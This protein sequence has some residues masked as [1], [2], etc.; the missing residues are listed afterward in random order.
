MKNEIL[1][2]SAQLVAAAANGVYQGLIITAVV[3]LCLRWL[4]R[5]NAATRHAIWFCTLLLLVALVVAHCLVDSSSLRRV[6]F[7][8]IAP[9]ASSQLPSMESA[10]QSETATVT[11]NG[12]SDSVSF[13][14]SSEADSHPL[15][16][17]LIQAQPESDDDPTVLEPSN[18]NEPED[19]QGIGPGL[20]ST[21]FG[22]MTDFRR[23]MERWLNPIPVELT[24]GSKFSMVATTLLGLGLFIAGLRVFALIVQLARIRKLKQHSL[25][26][27]AELGELFQKLCVRLATDRQV[28]LRVS[29]THRSSFLLGFRHPVV[30]LPAEEHLELMEAELILR[31]ELAHLERR[32]DW[33][34]LI[35]H[36][37]LAVFFFH[38][39]FWWIS[40]QLSLEREIAC[41]DH[42]LQQSKRPQVYAL[43][44]ANL[45][46]RMQRLPLLAP[47]SSNH[48]TQLK[49]RIDMILNTH[50]NASPRLA[51]ARLALITSLTALLAVAVTS[52]APRIVL[53]QNETPIAGAAV[54]PSTP[55]ASTTSVTDVIP[56]ATVAGLPHPLPSPTLTAG[57]EACPKY[58]SGSPAP[59]GNPP[60]VV[61]VPAIS[62]S[63]VTARLSVNTTVPGQPPVLAAIEAPSAPRP[64]PAP[65]PSKVPRSENADVLEQRLDRLERMLNSL[66]SQQNLKTRSDFQLRQ[67][68]GMI[69]R[70]EM[71]KLE[72]L[73]KQQAE[74]A[75]KIKPQEIEQI[76]EQATREAKHAAEQA[77]RATAGVEK[78]RKT[79]QRQAVTKL[80]EDSHRQ[81]ED[82][83]RQVEALE[84]QREK[85]DR[86][87]ERLERDQEDLNE[88]DDESAHIHT[89]PG[90]SHE[91]SITHSHSHT[92][93]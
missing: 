88:Q 13:R 62:L 19:A 57:V 1:N 4:V 29:P 27:A 79:N 17:A 85:L 64:Q 35:Q 46:A 21:T 90:L 43:V 91:A 47:G 51:G 22:G 69:D 54:P 44:L 9:P 42:V 32:D 7:T 50:R 41:D 2:A 80:K 24:I 60:T 34:N 66:M 76:K 65:R 31:H 56:V 77:K 45:A 89:S 25:P 28:E 74:L 52:A 6:T 38:P 49:E 61:T 23:S 71:A 26:P 11:R 14:E 82:L 84:R 86:E 39:A 93:Q 37:L 63:P 59:L 48:K 3:A 72:G 55:V 83:R 58:K 30:L 53:A 75:R 70:K 15:L 67:E 18:G 73:A 92:A 68:N 81:L 8:E 10:V 87:I 5:T 12:S 40:R 20:G 36:F 33:A 78:E 16:M